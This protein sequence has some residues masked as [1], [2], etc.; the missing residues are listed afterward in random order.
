ME[1]CLKNN[2][3]AKLFV[4]GEMGRHYFEK[5]GLEIA[6]QFHYTAQN[7]SVSRARNITEKILEEYLNKELDEVVIITLKC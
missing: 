6:H 5:K 4:V 7:P 3:H 1:E 2:S